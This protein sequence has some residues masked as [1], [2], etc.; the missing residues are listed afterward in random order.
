M[1]TQYRPLALVKV[2][3]YEYPVVKQRERWGRCICSVA[4]VRYSKLAFR[5]LVRLYDCD[6]TYT[7]M[8]LADSFYNSQQVRNWTLYPV[9]Y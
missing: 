5:L 9:H 6:L 8:I 4:Q 7:P 3:R 1:S 2:Q